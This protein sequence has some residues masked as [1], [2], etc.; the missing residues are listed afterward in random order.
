MTVTSAWVL[1][2]GGLLGSALGRA[3]A[4]SGGAAT[5]L[6]GPASWDDAPTFA[7]WVRQATGTFA[8]RMEASPPDEGRRWAVLWAAG[9]GTMGSRADE[10]ERETALL[11]SLLDALAATPELRR[12]PGSFAFSSTAGGIYAGSTD[13][14]ITE[15]SAPKPTGP[16]GEHKLKQEQIVAAWARTMPEASV[17]VARIS[18]LY[19]PGQ[20]ARK[21]QGLI[22]HIA[23]S[24]L[25]RQPVHIFV[26]LDTMRDYLYAD[27]AAHDVLAALA[28]LEGT[29]GVTTKI[30][31]AGQVT[32]VAQII[33][34]F[35]QIMRRM[36]RI[37]T[38]AHPLG[39]QYRHRMSFRSVVCPE[40]RARDRTSLL[41]GIAAVMAQER[42]AF[43]FSG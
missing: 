36:P 11:S 14:T 4:A 25:R 40:A 26:P 37:I 18:T 7:S 23:R 27:D 31:A 15:R 24:L 8:Q 42:L 5:D 28:A 38:S 39:A 1:G 2:R 12:R 9:Q 20:S 3:L 43:A 30:V 22:S 29:S 17:L 41:V 35:E 19:G 21:R 32:T 34:N 13:E 33:G 6:P 10:M 16:Y